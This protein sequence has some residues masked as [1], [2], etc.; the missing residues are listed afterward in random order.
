[1]IC[2]KMPNRMSKPPSLNSDVVSLILENIAPLERA[3]YS[4]VSKQWYAVV[5]MLK[6]RKTT[7]ILDC[8]EKLKKLRSEKKRLKTELHQLY[9]ERDKYKYRNQ[10][11]YRMLMH[12]ILTEYN[13]I[14]GPSEGYVNVCDLLTKATFRDV[15][16]IYKHT[17]QCGRFDV[18]DGAPCWCPIELAS[19]VFSTN[20]GRSLG[21]VTDSIPFSSRYGIEGGWDGIDPTLTLSDFHDYLARINSRF[22]DSSY[23]HILEHVFQRVLNHKIVWRDYMMRATHQTEMTNKPGYARVDVNQPYFVPLAGG[24]GGRLVV[25]HMFEP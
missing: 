9:Y 22:S 11:F 21:Y 18:H 16:I 7:A 1:M 8:E 6:R 4:R 17:K 15:T 19:L 24:P 5:G 23:T 25:P 10:N 13:R 2:R 3:K 20:V 14:F 12:E